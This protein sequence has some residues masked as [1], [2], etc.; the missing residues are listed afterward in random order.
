MKKHKVATIYDDLKSQNRFLKIIVGVQVCI[1]VLALLTNVKPPIVIRE[2]D[3]GAHV[4]T[5]YQ[6]DSFVSELDVELFFSTFVKKFNLVDSFSIYENIPDALSMMDPKLEDH[7][8]TNVITADLV[9]SIIDSKNRTVTTIK[10][11]DSTKEGSIVPA[12]ITYERQVI[13]FESG[14]KIK[15][16]V[17]GEA[18]LEIVERTV[19]Y[20]YGLKVREYKEIKLS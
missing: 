19:Q 20:P 5:D 17:R 11:I 8:K 12:T 7:Y 9:K 16:V 14:E 15:I 2:T 10:S 13:S 4:M 3:N 18:I 6:G 1:V